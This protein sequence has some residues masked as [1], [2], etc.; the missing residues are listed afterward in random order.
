MTVCPSNA[1]RADVSDMEEAVAD[2]YDRID[3]LIDYS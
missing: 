3:R 2:V 1:I